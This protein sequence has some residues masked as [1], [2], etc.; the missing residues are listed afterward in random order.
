MAATALKSPRGQRPPGRRGRWCTISRARPIFIFPPYL[1]TIS[2][3]LLRLVTSN[4]P[5]LVNYRQVGTTY[6]IDGLFSLAELRVGNGKTAEV[7]RIY[8]DAPQ[9]LVCP[10]DEHCPAWPDRVA[11]R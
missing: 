8:R 6:V 10:G 2:A 7:V 11:G 9:R 5:E 1:T 4:G 3:P